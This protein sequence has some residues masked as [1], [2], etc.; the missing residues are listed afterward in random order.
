MK[1]L[2]QDSAFPEPPAPRIGVGSSSSGSQRPTG[3]CGPFRGSG[4]ICLSSLS[5]RL[6]VDGM[7]VKTAGAEG[8]RG[9]WDNVRSP[10]SPG[11]LGE[12]GCF[13]RETL[14][15]HSPQPCHYP[16]SC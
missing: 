12:R 5:L 6:L 15:R 7:G 1:V 13:C 10:V 16:T 8:E 2:L 3:L 11:V 14:L 4:T 9:A